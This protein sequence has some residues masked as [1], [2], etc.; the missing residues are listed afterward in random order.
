MRISDIKEYDSSFRPYSFQLEDDFS[1][2]TLSS[3]DTLKENAITF[4]KNIKFLKSFLASFKTQKI[5]QV[6]LLIEENFFDSLKSQPEFP[7]LSEIFSGI[8][9]VKSVDLAMALLSKPFYQRKHCGRNKMVDGRQMGTAKVHPSAQIAQNVFIGE[10]VEIAEDVSIHPGVVIMGHCQ[11]GARTTLYP[12]VSLNDEVI[13]G[14]DCLIYSNTVLGSDGFGYHFHEGTHVK[15]WHLGGVMIKDHVEL[16]AACSID[17][18]TF[19][20]TVIG[21]GSKLDNMVHVGHNCILGKGVIICGQSA[22]SGSVKIGDY[23]VLGG[24]VGALPNIEIGAGSKL[25]SGT[26]IMKSCSQNVS[27]AGH[28]AGPIQD[29]FRG[30]I[31]MKNLV[32]QKT[33]FKS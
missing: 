18:G 8:G 31:I 24:Q 12:N 20:D 16:G 13:V 21:E 10:D 14:T 25:I 3:L 9:T 11:I 33:W 2:S 26:K 22:I 1:F 30:I 23:A 6:Y 7:F 28:P 15:V 4:L 19:K 17:R 29:W 5:H 32:Q 27:L